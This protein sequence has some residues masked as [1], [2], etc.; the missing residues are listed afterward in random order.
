MKRAPSPRPD[1]IETCSIEHESGNV[2]DFPMIQD[3][4]SLLWVVNLGCIDLNQWYAR[5]DDVDRPDYL[6]FDLD[7][8]PTATFDAGAR[9]G[10]PRARRAGRA[11][12]AEP[13]EDDRLARAS[14]S[15]CRSSAGRPRRTV[16]TFAK[17]VRADA[18]GG[19]SQDLITAEYRIAKRPEGRVLVDY[20]QNAW[21]RTLASI[22]SVRPRPNATVST[23]VTWDEVE[24]GVSDRGLHASERAR[25]RAEARRPL[26][27]ALEA[28]AAGSSWRAS[29]D[30]ADRIALSADRGA[31]RRRDPGRA[32]L[33]VRAEVGRLPLPRVPRRRRGRA[34][35]EGGQAAR[36]LLPRGRRGARG[37]HG[38]DASC[39]T[40]R[41]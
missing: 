12:D 14:T 31:A 20:N 16:W 9:D 26:E 8:V 33:A 39:S 2:I 35:V 30:A 25:A 38:A 15:T 5:C 17:A 23:P 10:A 41:S 37:A 6:H 7:P 4:A 22:Y 27:A 19:G 1:W 40:A 3:L 32:G 36:A 28:S 21:G 24:R 11:R 29:C 13:R 34:A 18:R